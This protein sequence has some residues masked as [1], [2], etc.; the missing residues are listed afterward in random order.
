[1]FNVLLDSYSTSPEAARMLGRASFLVAQFNDRLLLKVGVLFSYQGQEPIPQPPSWNLRNCFLKKITPF[2]KCNIRLLNMTYGLKMH[3]NVS[4]VGSLHFGSGPSFHQLPLCRRQH[5]SL[6]KKIKFEC[7]HYNLFPA[8]CNKY[9]GCCLD[10]MPLLQHYIPHARLQKLERDPK[11]S[12]RYSVPIC[13]FSKTHDQ[14]AFIT[15]LQP[16]KLSFPQIM[17]FCMETDREMCTVI[18]WW[19]CRGCLGGDNSYLF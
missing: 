2:S 11:I 9:H 13:P 10:S 17:R 7:W 4:R 15:R 18:F 19:K 3:K 1:M 14:N 5:W 8:I 6:F 12:L 16:V